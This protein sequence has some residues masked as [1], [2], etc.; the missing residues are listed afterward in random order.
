MEVDH[1]GGQVKPLTGRMSCVVE[2]GPVAM[3]NLWSALRYLCRGMRARDSVHRFVE[4]RQAAMQTVLPFSVSQE[5]CSSAAG[6]L[7]LS[8]P[9][10]YPLSSYHHGPSSGARRMCIIV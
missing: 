3:W 7:R 5:V 1:T 9:V 8:T 10:S 2:E 6:L 4:G